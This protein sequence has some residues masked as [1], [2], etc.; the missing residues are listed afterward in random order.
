M[1]NGKSQNAC[2]T[3]VKYVQCEWKC[4]TALLHLHCLHNRQPHPKYSLIVLITFQFMEKYGSN[5]IIK[6]RKHNTIC[7]I[8]LC[9]LYIIW[10]CFISSVVMAFKFY[11]LDIAFSYI[12]L[13]NKRKK[14]VNGS[15]KK[16]KKIKQTEYHKTDFRT[17]DILHLSCILYK[18][19]KLVVFFSL[20]SCTK[21][22][23][24]VYLPK[25]L[26]KKLQKLYNF[27]K[28]LYKCIKKLY[29]LV[30]RL[31]QWVE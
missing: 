18:S 29:I 6:P 7:N 27:N 20:E 25:K 16:K 17:I 13:Q 23:L 14:T 26:Y 11:T 9:S 28:R 2:T 19:F 10:A 31:P 24:V 15:R 21:P 3:V 22:F 5:T 30:V 8:L 12:W 1:P 4:E